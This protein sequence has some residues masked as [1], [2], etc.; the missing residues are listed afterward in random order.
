MASTWDSIR[1]VYPETFKLKFSIKLNFILSILFNLL[2][3]ALGIPCD[4]LI[5]KHFKPDYDLEIFFLG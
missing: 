5:L 3:Q 2:W 4:G 1:G